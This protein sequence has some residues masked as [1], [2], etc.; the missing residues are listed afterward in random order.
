[1]DSLTKFAMWFIA[2]TNVIL[3]S[4]VTIQTVYISEHIVWDIDKV[5]NTHVTDVAYWY[6]KGCE[7][8]THYPP[9]FKM[10]PDQFNVNSVPSWCDQDSRTWEEDFARSAWKLGR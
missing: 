3:I 9:E 7:A 10:S 2:T 6:K 1:M 4:M 5:R 8:G